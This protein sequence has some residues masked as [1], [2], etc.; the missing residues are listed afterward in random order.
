MKLTILVHL[1]A[2]LILTC[3]GL[4]AEAQVTA[5][6]AITV[7]AKDQRL[8]HV[9]ADLP[10]RDD[11][12]RMEP[13]YAEK[14]SDRW[15]KFIT[16]LVARN[17][18]GKEVKLDYL[19]AA[20][21]RISSP[22][23]Q[24]IHLEYFVHLDHD[25]EN[26]IWE[27]G[28]KEA[29]YAK[30]DWF[31]YTGRA[32]FIG[33]VAQTEAVVEV[34]VPSGWRVTTPW[35][36]L[37]NNTFKVSDFSELTNVALV[38]GK[39][40]E[41]TLKAG[42]TEVSI[43]LGADLANSMD[44]FESMVNPLLTHTATFFGGSPPGKF[45][46][47]ANRDTYTS[48]AAFTR[49]VSMVFKDPPSGQAK[50]F[51]AHILCHE[52]I[53]LWIGNAIRAADENRENWLAEGFTDYVSYDIL[54]SA[55]FLSRQD[56]LN[57]LQEESR[58]YAAQ[59]GHIS[60]RDAGEKKDEYYDLVYSGGFVVAAALDAQI[61]NATSGKHSLQTMIRTMY[62]QYGMPSKRYTI[63]DVIL[64]A[65]QEAG[66]DLSSFFSNYVRGTKIIDLSSFVPMPNR[67]SGVQQ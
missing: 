28:P 36:S 41:R 59:A 24:I 39:Y 29:A 48:G 42:Q 60:M 32:L 67:S 12:L 26:G 19:G 45:V 11:I 1:M 30:K 10:V 25:R 57:Q 51:V 18:T 55:G 17:E 23:P 52:M 64:L 4:A 37:S 31:F 33:T 8:N 61:S 47:L 66:V 14:L 58:N 63:D 6:Y 38:L 54:A 13:S 49:S 27:F 43:A 15:A 7:D 35:K 3:A 21:W 5:H 2:A 16:H 56:V 44:L 34:K 46:I 9:S 20:R 65:S 50:A 62:Q 40:P 22:L 53:H